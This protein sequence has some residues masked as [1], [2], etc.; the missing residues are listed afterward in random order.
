MAVGEVSSQHEPTLTAHRSVATFEWCV[1]VVDAFVLG[2]VSV[3]DVVNG[4]TIAAKVGNCHLMR[5][6]E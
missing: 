6:I 4:I 3:G 1:P 2:E 5:V